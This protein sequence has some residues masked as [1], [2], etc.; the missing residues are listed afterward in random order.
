MLTK[1]WLQ[2]CNCPNV[3]NTST[4]LT[5]NLHK[6]SHL[7]IIPFQVLPTA[8]VAEIFI[9]FS[10]TPT[11]VLIPLPL[12]IW[13]PKRKEWS[14]KVYFRFTLTC[15]SRRIIQ[16]ISQYSTFSFLPLTMKLFH[17]IFRQLFAANLYYYSA[18]FHSS[19]GLFFIHVP[20][21]DPVRWPISRLCSFW[22]TLF[23]LFH[24][25]FLKSVR[26]ILKTSHFAGIFLINELIHC[27]VVQMN[28]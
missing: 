16:R 24:C 26:S 17:R 18:S 12:S 21:E 3:D 11:A 2:F 28:A 22:N 27:S 9:T 25:L 13:I 4:T 23:I 1:L 8:S 6:D 20:A 5:A 19:R 15:Q 10:S 7:L 14:Q